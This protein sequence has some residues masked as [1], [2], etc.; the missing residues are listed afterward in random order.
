V[1]DR[2]RRNDASG[3]RSEAAGRR[4]VVVFHEPHLGGATRSVTRIVPILGARGWEFCF[5]VPRPSGL[6]D[7][8]SAEGHDVA[9]APR[10]IEYSGRAWRLPPG[11]MARARSIPPYLRRFREYVRDRSPDLVHANSIMTLT[12]ALTA[13]ASGLAVLLHVHE[14]LPGDLRGRLLRRAAWR[15]DQVVAVSNA[16]A[17]PL[18]LNGRTPR[19]VYEGTPVP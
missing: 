13:H 7:H 3:R 17:A 1:S 6:F 19:I 16:S 9:G 15:L 11:P 14:M 5:W 8:L 4:V 18:R 10:H 2:G 12:E